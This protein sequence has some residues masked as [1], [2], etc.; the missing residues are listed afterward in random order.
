M[1]SESPPAGA[2][3]IFNYNLI[4]L[5]PYG[6]PLHLQTGVWNFMRLNEIPTW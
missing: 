6:L 2:G 1:N 3:G 5:E 4:V